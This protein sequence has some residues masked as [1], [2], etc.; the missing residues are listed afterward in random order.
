MSGLVVYE[1]EVAMQKSTTEAWGSLLFKVVS[2]PFILLMIGV[3]AKQAISL[4]HYYSTPELSQPA[5][6]SFVGETFY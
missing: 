1:G 4:H 6:E 2:V 3:I 5:S